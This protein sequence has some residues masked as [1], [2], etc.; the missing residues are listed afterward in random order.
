MVNIEEIKDS[1]KKSKITEQI[2]RSLPDWFEL[3]QGILDY[4]KSVQ[5]MPFFITKINNK[6]VGFV[7]IEDYN[8]FTSEIHVMGIL[9]G[10][11]GK[12]IGRQ[13]IDFVWDRNIKLGK[14]YL[15]VKTLDY[16]AGDRFYEETRKFYFAMGFVPIM[17]L[18]DIWGEDNPCVIMIKNR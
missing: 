6:I 9:P 2:L 18:K 14:K 11:R 5:S 10:F 4:I 8:E 1:D 17:I 16:S 3:E 15:T 7:V 13:I 12:G